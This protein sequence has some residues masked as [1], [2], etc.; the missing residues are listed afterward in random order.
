MKQVE[1]VLGR[2]MVHEGKEER[3]PPMV[4]AAEASREDVNQLRDKLQNKPEG[5][6]ASLGKPLA[7]ESE[8][9]RSLPGM[10][11]LGWG[12]MTGA[13]IFASRNSWGTSISRG[14]AVSVQVLNTR[15][16]EDVMTSTS[17]L[18][19]DEGKALL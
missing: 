7:H 13:L 2:P 16:Q 12:G 14:R 8:E 15:S 10:Q 4:Q 11:A 9:K 1:V 5:L 6:E 19:P 17:D 3:K 18:H